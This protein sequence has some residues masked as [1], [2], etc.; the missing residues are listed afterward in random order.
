MVMT[1]H[2]FSPVKCLTIRSCVKD[3]VM[4]LRTTTHN[5]FPIVDKR[6]KKMAAGFLPSYGRLR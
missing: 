3:V 2:A 5:A 6:P 4:L 1:L